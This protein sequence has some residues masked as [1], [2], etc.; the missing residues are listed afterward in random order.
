MLRIQH[1]ILRNRLPVRAGS[2]AWRPLVMCWNPS[3]VSIAQ[4][5]APL[6]SKLDSPTQDS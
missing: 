4:I 3:L 5:S 2:A 1:L 6:T